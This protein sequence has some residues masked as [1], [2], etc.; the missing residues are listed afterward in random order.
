MSLVTQSEADL[1]ESLEDTNDFGWPVTLTDPAGLSKPL[2]GSSTDISQSIDPDTGHVI[3]GRSASV[4]LRISSI[5]GAGF[6]SLPKGIADTSG[7]P[8]RVT[9]DDVNGSTYNFKVQQSNPDLKIGIVVC[10][11]EEYT[12][13]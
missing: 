6:A 9:F 4:A 5:Y 1:A 3:S 11:L 2:N 8:W 13:V 10:L 12:V 7:K